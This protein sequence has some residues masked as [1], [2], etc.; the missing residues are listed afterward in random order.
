M[1][2]LMHILYIL[3]SLIINKQ[4]IQDWSLALDVVPCPQCNL[5][6]YMFLFIY[7]TKAQLNDTYVQLLWTYTI[8]NITYVCVIN[9]KQQLR[10]K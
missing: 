3:T 4:V 8:I 10:L 5:I 7:N 6:K 2:M 9:M 1:H